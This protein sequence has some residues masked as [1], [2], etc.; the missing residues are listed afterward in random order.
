MKQFYKSKKK[1]DGL[2]G[3]RVNELFQ[4]F[5]FE[6]KQEKKNPERMKEIVEQI[7]ALKKERLFKEDFPSFAA[8][9]RYLKKEKVTLKDLL[10]ND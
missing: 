7:A 5:H 9:T 10:A 2:I 3:R 1:E 6:L 8:F 4:Q